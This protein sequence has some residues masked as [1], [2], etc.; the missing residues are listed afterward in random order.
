MARPGIVYVPAVI[1]SY[2]YWFVC[3]PSGLIVIL[4]ALVAAGVRKNAWGNLLT[5]LVHLTIA[6]MFMTY[7]DQM[8]L[9]Y[10]D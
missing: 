6:I 3:F 7:L 5:I 1:L 8:W 4:L 9:L 10:G 2:L